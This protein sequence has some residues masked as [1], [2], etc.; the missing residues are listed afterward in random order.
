MMD[1]LKSAIEA[2]LFAAGDSV[3]VSKLS[4]V[5]AC[6]EET[7]LE[8]AKVLEDEYATQNRGV[9]LL[10]L[11]D[12]LQICSSP[13][14]ADDII[15]TLDEHKRPS[16]SQPALEV[17]TIVAYFQPVTRAYIE[18]MRGV[19]SSYTIGALMERGLIEISGR[20]EAPG[21]PA[22]FRTTDAFLRVMGIS[23]PEELP[24]LPDLKTSDGTEQLRQRVEELRAAENSDQITMSELV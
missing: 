22:L 7:I 10:R 12:K 9:R 8:A 18:T 5:F 17:L 1:N 23:S 6:E 16:L 20:L 4:L 13:E 21:R 14:W 15:R 24:P 11:G 3:P 19:D 2:V